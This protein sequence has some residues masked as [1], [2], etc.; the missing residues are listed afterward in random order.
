MMIKCGR[1]GY[2]TGPHISPDMADHMRA[3]RALPPFRRI[4]YCHD[5]P[6]LDNYVTETFAAEHGATQ[7]GDV[8]LPD[9]YPDWFR[10][11]VPYCGKCVEEAVERSASGRT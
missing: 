3:G 10:K 8:A 9:D 5:G 1:H 7:E 11:L 6:Y 2:Q 4:T